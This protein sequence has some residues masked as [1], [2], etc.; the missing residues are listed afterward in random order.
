MSEVLQAVRTIGEQCGISN[1]ELTLVEV[2]ALFH[3]GEYADIYAVHEALGINIAINT[4][5]SEKE[6][7]E[8]NLDLM[9]YHN[10]FTD[11]GLTVLEDFKA[12]D[13]KI[14]EDRLGLLR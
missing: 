5:F 7:A 2:A 6:W 14:I 10:Y 4:I 13:K 8:K 9:I 11:Y 1:N 3:D 12:V